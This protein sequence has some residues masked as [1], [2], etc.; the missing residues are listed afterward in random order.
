M[1]RRALSKIFLLGLLALA[2]TNATA[3]HA[4]LCYDTAE[5]P[6]G[7][8]TSYN[9]GSG[10]P[11][12]FD[13]NLVLR[14]TAPSGRAYTVNGFFDG[15]GAGGAVGS[16]FKA[17][18][19]ADEAGT[20]RW[21]VSSTNVPG[22]SGKSGS[23]SVSGKLTGV[24][25]QGPVVENP[26]RPRT[27]M[28]RSGKPVFLAGKFL[29]VAA[30]YPIQY[31]H[32]LLSEKLTDT[33]RQA[34]LS[35]HLGMKLNKMNVYYANRGDYGGLATTPWVGTASSNNKTRFDLARWRMYDSWIVKLR[36]AGMVAQMWFF[37]DD[38][39]FGDLPD[40][41]RQ[42]LI[43]Y[44]MARHS[45]YVNTMYVLALEW[46][47]GW[48]IT[49]VTNHA[50]FL[51]QQNPWARM[52]TVHGIPG[53]FKFPAASW[54]DYMD[55]QAGNTVGHGVVHSLGLA[56]RLLASK[57]LI[58]EEHAMGEESTAN[59]QK[60]WAAFTGGAAAVGTGAF[61]GP[62][63]TFAAQVP[64][65]RMEPADE[66]VRSGSAYGL[67]EKGNAY[68]FYLYNGGAAGVDLA[69]VSGTLVAQW[70]DPRTG[71]WSSAPSANGGGIRTY[72]SPA[73]GDW[74]LYLHR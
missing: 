35:R 73:S 33:N 41:D 22:L 18:V 26:A 48:S 56:N 37:A 4:V 49:E 54:A 67:A 16:V 29:D 1:A 7:S 36:N 25:G 15:N 42:R 9:A 65:E 61:L 74:V 28:Y 34:M 62:L 39:G 24:F 60:A 14:V 21:S 69:G 40:V 47:E 53:D 51:H 63:A 32:T 12:P 19:F 44:A 11:S 70:Y 2:A 5:I 64:F 72:F 8:T 31:S 57:P 71:A 23:F 55:I 3:A 68:V 30:S 17:R 38:S 66:L 46:Q 13:L 20:W 43:K 10:V 59:R 6:L 50:N 58:Q 52:L 45:A 27:F